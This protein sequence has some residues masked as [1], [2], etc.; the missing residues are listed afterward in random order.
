MSEVFAAPAPLQTAVLFLVFNR[1]DT[2]K[3]VFEAI[4]QARPNRLYVAADGPRA[5]RKGE[6]EHAE[7]VRQ[8]ATAV[9]WACEVKTLFRNENLGCK[10]AVS[11]GIDWFFENEE[12]GIILEDDCYPSI[13]FFK[14]A[15]ELLNKY[16]YDMRI[17]HISG[18]CTLSNEDIL[19]EDSYYFSKFNHIWG[20]ATWKDR[21]GYYDSTM[22]SYPLFVKEKY[23]NNIFRNNK[24]CRIWIKN[25]NDVYQNKINTWD[26]QWY[27]TTWINNGLSIIPS[28]NLVSNIGFGSGATHTTDASSKLANMQVDGFFEIK[29]HPD[30]ISQ[31]HKKDEINA[32]NLF[33][34]KGIP[35]L[36]ML[37]RNIKSKL[38]KKLCGNV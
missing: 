3:Q 18:V 4:R 21:W 31:N 37:I 13:A 30:I 2:T 12:Q 25:F 29:K 22:P 23:I 28:K 8:I 5:N 20:W 14:F 15:E 19:N 38:N 7:Q 11:S 9:D 32:L 26:Y 1:P 17:W 33:E 34:H 27:F 36:L 6:A 10:K 24:L 16:K 35:R